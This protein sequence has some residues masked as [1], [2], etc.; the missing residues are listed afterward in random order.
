MAMIFT[1]SQFRPRNAGGLLNTLRHL[2]SS[3]AGKTLVFTAILWLL[4]FAACKQLLWRD[5][6]AAFFSETGVYELDYS[7]YRQAEAHEFIQHATTDARGPRPEITKPAPVICAAITTFNRDGHQYLN[8][9]VGSMLVGLTMEERSVLDVR[10]LFAHAEG[11]V[12]PDWDSGWLDTLD[13]WGG[14]NVSKEDLEHIYELETTQ[15]F[16]AKGV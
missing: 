9:T 6:H 13:H 4:I 8:E 14:Y 10:L 15:N 11:A 12:H 7:L 16:Y 2:V 1:A 5:P 3:L